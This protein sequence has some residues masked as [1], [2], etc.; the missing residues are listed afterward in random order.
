MTMAGLVA[1]LLICAFMIFHYRL[2]GVVAS[3]ALLMQVVGILLAIAIPQ[4]TLTL[5]GIAYHPVDRH[6]C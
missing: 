2:P 4:Q 5:Q 3:F 6:G 1:F